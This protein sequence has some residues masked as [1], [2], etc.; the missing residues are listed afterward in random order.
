MYVCMYVSMDIY[1]HIHTV[2]SCKMCVC[3][4]IYTYL[5]AITGCN[6]KS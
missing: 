5:L 2:K 4:Y 3:I 1:I 6:G